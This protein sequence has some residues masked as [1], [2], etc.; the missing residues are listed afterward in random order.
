[1][2][3]TK[4]TEYVLPPQIDTLLAATARYLKGEGRNDLVAILANARIEIEEGADYDN[5]DGGQTGHGIR[6]HVPEGL[7]HPAISNAESDGTELSKI[8][9]KLADVPHEHISYVRICLDL[10]TI[11]PNWR[12]ET[13]ALLAP[14]T[15]ATSSDSDQTRLWGTGAPRVFLSHRADFKAETKQ[16]KD[17]LT[18]Y[19][20][21]SF[22]AHEDIEP[23]RAWQAEIE[24][25]LASMDVLVAL[26]TDGFAGSYWSNQEV[27]VALG[28]G[29][30]VITVRISEDPRGFIGGSQAISGHARTP[31]EWAKGLIAAFSGHSRLTRPL[32]VGLVNQWEIA[33]NFMEAIRVMDLLDASKT[34]PADLLARIE[35]AFKA[36]DQLHN[37][38]GVHRKYP[39]FLARMKSGAA[40]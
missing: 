3:T 12:E 1:M 31:S 11:S 24:R 32:L 18:R 37:S 13:G 40:S 19:G 8:L 17:E 23:T 35:A 6:L 22:V 7:F 29:V 15:L 36:N 27:G 30:P 16:L 38:G 9:N 34:M 20:A 39:A 4:Q 5:W 28:R 33:P 26:L 2:N 21:A 14:P 10:G 25:A